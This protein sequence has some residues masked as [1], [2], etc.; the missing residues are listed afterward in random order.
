MLDE[1]FNGGGA[2][3][4]YMIEV[5]ERKP[6]FMQTT[7][8]GMEVTSP[9]GAIYGPK[10]ML[11]NEYAG[12][13]G[14]ALPYMFHETKIGP[15][16]GRRTWGGLVG[17]YD[18]PTLMDGMTVT[19]PRIAIYTMRGQWEIENHGVAPDV[20]VDLDPAAWRAGRDSQ[21]EKGV[22]IALDS[23]AKHPPV[24]VKRPAYPNYHG[25][26]G[27]AVSGA[28]GGTVAGAGHAP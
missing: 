7:R 27:V 2:I 19:A 9:T 24:V 15:L 4:D 10:V 21:L 12:S 13:G 8:Q 5:M 26:E 23:L 20:E 11:V 28:V 14:D 6:L 25:G 17:I 3:A 1:R 16:V 22:A 18:Y